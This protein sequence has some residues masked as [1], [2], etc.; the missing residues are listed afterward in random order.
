MTS[1]YER[2]AAVFLK[3][4]LLRIG[5]CLTAPG[6]LML[7]WALAHYNSDPNGGVGAIANNLLI[8]LPLLGGFACVG[9]GLLFCIA[10]LLIAV[11]RKPKS[12]VDGTMTDSPPDRR[13]FVYRSG[14]TEDLRATR[15][16]QNHYR[17]EETSELAEGT[18]HDVV[19]A[20]EQADGSLAFQRIVELSG[21]VMTRYC[22]PD[23]VPDMEMFQTILQAV[24]A[25]GAHYERK[26]GSVLLVHARPALAEELRLRIN[27]LIDSVPR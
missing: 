4:L 25:S 21:L 13:R 18:F 19:E 10:A 22:L 15:I 6:L 3:L 12:G 2:S 1:R 14:Q 20:E 16:G 27:S 23:A 7:F 8:F 9:I 5:L 11:L 17:L 26:P 24:A